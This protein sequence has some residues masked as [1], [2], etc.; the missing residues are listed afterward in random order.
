MG[1]LLFQTEKYA[2][3]IAAYRRVPEPAR[4]ETMAARE[5]LSLYRLRRV[6]EAN[7]AAGQFKKTYKTATEWLARFEVEKGR[8]QLAVRNPKK[9]A[10]NF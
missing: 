7:K 4:N 1:D 5:V 8:Y 2:Q 10:T 9:S 3:A 6:G